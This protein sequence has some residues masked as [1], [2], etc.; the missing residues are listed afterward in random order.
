MKRLAA[1]QAV[2]FKAGAAPVIWA[3]LL[4]SLI[5]IFSAA[6]VGAA[7]QGDLIPAQQ[8]PT[9][10]VVLREGVVL[11]REI[12]VLEMAGQTLMPAE[13]V[14]E[15][16]GLKLAYGKITGTAVFTG[17]FAAT[18]PGAGGDKEGQPGAGGRPGTFVFYLG[19]GEVLANGRLVPAGAPPIEVD[20]I[21]FV[22]LAPF[23]QNFGWRLTTDR[24]Y[25]IFSLTREGD[26][27][28]LVDFLAV[29]ATPEKVR[30]RV[31]ASGAG[32]IDYR[33]RLA[34]SGQQL[35]V[36]LPDVYLAGLPSYTAIESITVKG[37]RPV[38]TA[39]R[40]AQLVIDLRYPAKA[41]QVEIGS[42]A[43]GLWVQLPAVYREEFERSIAQGLTYR[44]I[45]Q[46]DAQGPVVADI[47]QVDPGQPG[48]RIKPV[49]ATGTVLG[50]ETLSDIA[51]HYGALAGINGAF[52][53]FDGQPLGMLLIDGK[54]VSEPIFNRAAFGLVAG[55]RPVIQNFSFNAC[56][57][58][59]GVAYPLQG[60]N[61]PRGQG[62]IILYTRENGPRTMTGN[63]GREY[64]IAG[65]QVTGFSEGNTEIPPDGS[66]LS[67]D[68]S[69]RDL[70]DFI[71]PG[72]R[73]DFRLGSDPDWA[74]MGITQ[75]VGGGPRLIRD[76]RIE[77]STEMEQFKPDVAIGRAPRTAIGIAGDGTVL[78]VA[79]SG[80]QSTV[81]IGM[82]LEELA[83][84]MRELGA[85]EAMN[86]DGGGSTTLVADGAV[87]NFPSDGRERKVGTAI[88]IFVGEEHDVQ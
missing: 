39:Q 45:R 50:R 74:E 1:R 48:L 16:F 14:A 32:P 54:L 2:W 61:R 31:G 36:D 24:N 29:E 58:I 81:S 84:F 10:R 57:V 35:I 80:R 64:V 73:V 41:S 27:F 85:V 68:A 56:V 25:S 71:A 7:S 72:S 70:M 75:A 62:E 33:W 60:V 77:I 30:I 46:I 15:T 78:L 47:L 28:V 53:A 12:P 26:N 63:N 3:V 20:G 55:R 65:G 43:G 34:D 19:Q 79:V 17:P 76:G 4:F 23:L 8:F 18:T 88:L 83:G 86:L 82:T 42:E 37:I 13:F 87:L 11:P 22:P 5:G 52:F 38:Q 6:G 21:L 51:E 66:V 67:I 49:L 40:M 44:R 59:D 9:S 69:R